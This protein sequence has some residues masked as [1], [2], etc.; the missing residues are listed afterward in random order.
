MQDEPEVIMHTTEK[1]E[2]CFQRIKLATRP[3][4]HVYGNVL[5]Q[6]IYD[7]VPP[8]ELLTKVI[9]EFLTVSQPHCEVIARVLFQVR[10]SKKGIFFTDFLHIFFPFTGVS[11]SHRL[12]ISSPVARL[13]IMFITKF[14][15]ISNSQNNVVS[16]CNFHISVDKPELD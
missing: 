3:A 2:T 12:C 13:A 6:L 7:L 9:K 16:H 4:A 15:Y 8:K 10:Y 14:R 5:C 11:I 1:I